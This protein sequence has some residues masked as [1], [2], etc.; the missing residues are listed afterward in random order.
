MSVIDITKILP[1]NTKI[2]V[3]PDTKVGQTEAGLIIPNGSQERPQTGT[4]IAVGS[5]C[6]Y[7]KRNE[8]VMYGKSVG[9]QFDLEVEEG[10]LTPYFIMD[11]MEISMKI[12]K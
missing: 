8:R 10:V 6:K 12:K 11:E 4:V 2:L 3:L 7:I 9:M 1:C 5:F